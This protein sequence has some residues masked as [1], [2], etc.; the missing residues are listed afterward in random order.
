MILLFLGDSLVSKKLGFCFKIAVHKYWGSAFG[1]TQMH[2]KSMS[3]FWGNKSDFLLLYL[4]KN[5]Y[6]VFLTLWALHGAFSF[7][8]L[9]KTLKF[10]KS[11]CVTK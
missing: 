9:L 2:A 10:A 8:F 3:R 1:P 5:K 6:C 11:N 4:E 7:F